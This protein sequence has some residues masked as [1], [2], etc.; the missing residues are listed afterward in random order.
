MRELSIK[1][2]P[3]AFA[4]RGVATTISRRDAIDISAW[5]DIDFRRIQEKRPDFGITLLGER[6]WA[7]NFVGSNA[8]LL[9]AAR[10][11]REYFGPGLL[12]RLR[13]PNEE[14]EPNGLKIAVNDLNFADVTLGEAPTFGAWCSDRYAHAEHA[15][16]YEFISFAPNLLKSLPDFTERLIEWSVIRAGTIKQRAELALK[17]YPAPDRRR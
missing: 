16:R 10:D 1:E 17:E 6:R 11:D 12:C 5:S 2:A 14:V 3:E 4:A 9:L 15:Q 7:V 13:M 8:I